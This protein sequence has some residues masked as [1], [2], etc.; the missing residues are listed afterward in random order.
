MENKKYT[1]LLFDAD[2]TLFDFTR[3]EKDAFGIVM[4]RHDIEFDAADFERYKNYN[5]S[6]WASYGR[7]EITKEFLQR[8][9]F[10]AFLPDRRGRRG[11]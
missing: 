1:T 3:A 2:M 6:L 10:A 5:E 8:E 7:G 11:A 4:R 9:R